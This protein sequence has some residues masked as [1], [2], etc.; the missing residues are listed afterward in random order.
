MSFLDA[1]IGSFGYIP[2]FGIAGSHEDSVFVCLR[3]L[4]SVLHN[5]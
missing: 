2:R 3:N 4:H 5:G 1:D